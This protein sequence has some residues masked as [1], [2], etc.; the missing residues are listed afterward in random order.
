MAFSSMPASPLTILACRLSLSLSSLTQ[1]AATM[2]TK[3]RQIIN[4][5]AGLSCI[6][7]NIARMMLPTLLVFGLLSII[8]LP[9]DLI[10]IACRCQ[11]AHHGH[12]LR[13]SGL[14]LLQ[15]PNAGSAQ[16]GVVIDIGNSHV[17]QD[18]LDLI[19]IR[20]PCW[21]L[22]QAALFRPVC[23]P[24]AFLLRRCSAAHQ[25]CSDP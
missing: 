22:V 10:L 12:V 14:I 24:P 11:H 20:I 5:S 7:L 3:F 6:S 19:D 21:L 4:A 8:F 15:V 25:G 13:L 9:P 18:G 1:V 2:H 17:A 16:I 23:L